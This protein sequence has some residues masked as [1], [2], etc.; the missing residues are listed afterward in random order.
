MLRRKRRAD[1]VTPEVAEA[2]MRRDLHGCV[3]QRIA[4]VNQ[5]AITP[6]DGRA[7]LDHVRDEPM[8][9]KRAPSDPQ[10][11]VT[12]CWH[13]HLDGWATAHRAELRAYLAQFNESDR[14]RAVSVPPA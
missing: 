3:A 5:W 1:P 11:L 8:M 4:A 9:G 7:T 2:V 13:H 12:L 14:D 6:C 10:H